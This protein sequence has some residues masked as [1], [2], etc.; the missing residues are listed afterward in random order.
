VLFYIKICIDS[1]NFLNSFKF[2][3]KITLLGEA[4]F[5]L[6]CYNNSNYKIIKKGNYCFSTM[7]KDTL[8]KIDDNEE[9]GGEDA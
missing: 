6:T 5:F 8:P 9:K 3:Q 2:L 7:Q 4:I 1:N